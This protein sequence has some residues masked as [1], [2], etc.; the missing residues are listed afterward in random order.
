M[1]NDDE[2]VASILFQDTNSH[3]GIFGARSGANSKNY[4]ATYQS[5]KVTS[6]ASGLT[7]DFNNSSNAPYRLGLTSIPL[8]TKF[9]IIM[10]KNTRK[11]SDLGS[12]T[13]TCND[14]FTTETPCY[15]F[16]SSGNLFATNVS[17]FIG[18][19]YSFKIKGKF[20]GIPCYEKS[21]PD[22]VG[23]YDLETD[24][25]FENQG[26]GTFIAGPEVN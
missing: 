3:Q 10:N 6:G 22:N 7:L 15:I 11:F 25:F 5:P 18:R 26:T 9:T 24:T 19:L 20:N 14:T 16:Y 17:K 13:T 21:N 4:T 23:L 1:T 12:N 8:N 2:I